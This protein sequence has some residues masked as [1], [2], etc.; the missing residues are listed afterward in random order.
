[1]HFQN[2]RELKYKP[3]AHLNQYP[4]ISAVFVLLMPLI[5]NAVLTPTQKSRKK[6]SFPNVNTKQ[7]TVK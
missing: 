3:F 2:P 4:C 1:M 7:M 6:N 5:Q